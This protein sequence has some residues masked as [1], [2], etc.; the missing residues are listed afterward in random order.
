MTL[1]DTITRVQDILTSNGY[2]IRSEKEIQHGFQFVV[3]KDDFAKTL[4]IYFSLKKGSSI[5]CS[6]LGSGPHALHIMSLLAVPVKSSPVV[7]SVK[8]LS[9]PKIGLDE[10]GKGD[11]FGP[12][13]TACVYVED[14]KM[15]SDLR[16]A[17][18]KDSKL[19]SDTQV[20][21]IAEKI[22]CL[23]EKENY[24]VNTV[25]PSLYND[26]YS[27][28]NN[29]NEMLAH[30]HA[31][32]V[33]SLTSQKFLTPDSTIEGIR[34]AYKNTTV[35]VDQFNKNEELMRTYLHAN[36]WK[37]VIQMPRAESDVAVAAAS[38]LARSDFLR[39]MNSIS[40][41]YSVPVPKGA[42]D[43]VISAARHII[44]KHGQDVLQNV[45][46]LHFKTTGK[47][48]ETPAVLNI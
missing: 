16:K 48:L 32:T 8:A 42:S 21:I 44:E 30:T 35:V 1:T 22:K 39:Y 43:N 15:G 3:A 19:L 40:D 2:E 17:G 24:Y 38:I 34:K 5:D 36:Q 25:H 31:L 46:K 11:Y 13:V 14:E 26:I 29:L 6:Q 33:D 10:S 23:L 45:A 47:V 28:T 9:Y 20:L 12:L 18:V 37:E 7:D 27:D 41:K 4:R